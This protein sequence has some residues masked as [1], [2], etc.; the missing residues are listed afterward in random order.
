MQG[1]LDL[2]PTFPPGRPG[3]QG[4]PGGWVGGVGSALLRTGLEVDYSFWGVTPRPEPF[5]NL[6][7]VK[8]LGYTT[9][10]GGYGVLILPQ[11]AVQISN[12]FFM[13]GLASPI[14][15]EFPTEMEP[16]ANKLSVTIATS[17]DTVLRH[18]CAAIEESH[19]S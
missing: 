14:A 17:L 9:R 16:M 5:G 18:F 11:N 19:P 7:L 13:L 8:C 15:K 4:G 3:V 6:K 1:H 2:Q 10:P 12:L